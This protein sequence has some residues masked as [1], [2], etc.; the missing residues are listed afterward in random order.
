[1]AVKTV[2][3]QATLIP[4]RIAV[5]Y[6]PDREQLRPLAGRRSL[7]SFSVSW[8]A[9]EGQ[10][11]AS[12]IGPQTLELRFEPGVNW[13]PS[14]TWEE[15]KSL[16]PVQQRMQVGA[17]RLFQPR[18]VGESESTTRYSEEDAKVM[19][20]NTWDLVRLD[21]WFRTERRPS[22]QNYIQARIEAIRTG[23][24]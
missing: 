10:R 4:N 9:Q 24:V 20:D 22:V 8:F 17:L 2:E 7:R 5:V 3:Q 12:G 18:E 13:I 15:I 1:M 23:R 16:A 11:L 6:D 14:Q 21:N 19:V